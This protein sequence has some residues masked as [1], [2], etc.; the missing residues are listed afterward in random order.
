MRDSFRTIKGPASAR[1]TRRKSR[2]L[3][4]AEPVG[5]AEN[6]I[7]ALGDLRKSY[8]DATHVCSAHRLFADEAPLSGSDDDGE[9]SGSAGLP[10]LRQIEKANLENVL[11]AVV[12][13]FGGTK[14]GVGGLVRAYS[15][16]AAEALD[17]AGLVLEE[18]E[19][20]LTIEFPPEVTSGVM[21]TIHRHQAAVRH[22]EYDAV[23]LA[24]VGIPPSR[25]ETFAS[26]IQD[27]TAARARVVIKGP[28][29]RETEH[30]EE[31]DS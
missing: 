17:R 13:Y 21:G 3:A 4:F 15:D 30:R 2:F 16:A 25:A 28:G 22:I 8:H 20:T 23:G 6:V 10:I 18:L 27:A 14:L 31:A 7:A 24:E 5:S 9:P 29:E 11:V 1:I 12:R 26:A 19:S